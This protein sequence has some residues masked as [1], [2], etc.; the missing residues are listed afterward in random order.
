MPTIQI[1]SIL[2]DTYVN[3]G[4]P[5]NSYGSVGQ[6]ITGYDGVNNYNALIDFDRTQLNALLGKKIISATLDVYCYSTWYSGGV[7]LAAVPIKST[8][9]NN[10]TWS[11]KPTVDLLNPGSY[12]NPGNV[13]QTWFSFDIKK[14]LEFFAAGNTF[15]GIALQMMNFVN[16]GAYY[17]FYSKESADSRKPVLNV[18]YDDN[19]SMPVVTAPNGGETVDKNYSI[20]WSPATDAETV[21]SLL[22]YHIQLSTNNGSTWKDVVVLTNVGVTSYTYDFTNEPETSTAKIRIRAYDGLNYGSWDESNGVF[23]VSHSTAPTS[24]TNLSPSSSAISRN[25][26]QRF[27]WQHN[28]P[29]GTDPQ[30][31]FNL[32]WRIQGNSTWNTVTQ[33][34]TNSYYD[35]PANTLP[36]GTIEWRVR[37]YDQG[38]LVSPYSTIAV[39]NVGETP[40]L[41]IITSPTNGAT[42]SIARPN[43]QWSAPSQTDY[44]VKV[45]NAA[46]TTIIWE[47]VKTSTNKAVTIGTN[48]NNLTSYKIQVA[49]KN[50]GLWSSFANVDISMSFIPPAVPNVGTVKGDAYI[51]INIQDPT[52]SGSQ[53]SVLYHEV[54]KDIEGLFVL[55]ATN[56]M[57][58][59]KDYQVK[60][61]ET[62]RYFVR[63]IGT[64]STFRDTL[65]ISE[66]IDFKGVWLHIVDSP[67]DSIHQ[68]KFD[69]G[70]R[71]SKWELE[72]AVHHF[73]GR[74]RPVIV[75]GEME[76]FTVDFSL[77]ILNDAERTAL[78]E[79]VYSQQTVC[80]RD[81][82]G[83]K[84]FGVFVDAPLSDEIAKSYSTK[85]S[86]MQID[87]REGI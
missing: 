82:R 81:G 54:Y 42:V 3:Q 60:S 14:L 12:L 76:L 31:K 28:D 46:G 15:H 57:S 21:Q 29:N 47:E 19:P 87:F 65:I 52:P 55:V 17:S 69:G 37:T 74:K 84:V 45:L 11:N 80:Y 30:S 64:N 22:K 44:H 4:L 25:V 43:V 6:M 58:N 86:L 77:K 20:T 70:G 79:I 73:Q 34:T 53:P 35:M 23:S 8:W 68:F 27:S 16:S 63:A 78:E 7:S 38:G 26:G 39:V 36:V 59:F 41:P 33:T 49:V 71:T 1:T 62:T 9:D 56:V 83:R 13:S 51:Q 61:G 10:T 24:P 50:T 18:V 67:Q 75:T 40:G 48:L 72:N 32:D 66:A 5:G 2:K 85:L